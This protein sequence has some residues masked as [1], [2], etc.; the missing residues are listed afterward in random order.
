MWYLIN[1]E[2]KKMRQERK[3]KYFQIPF[4]KAANE[5]FRIAQDNRLSQGSFPPVEYCPINIANRP[6]SLFLLFS[7]RH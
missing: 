1:D 4:N 7:A 2:T 5:I 6:E 3:T